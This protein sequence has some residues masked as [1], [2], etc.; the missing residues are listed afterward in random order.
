LSRDRGNCSDHCHHNLPAAAIVATV[1]EKA[2][3][4]TRWVGARW[5]SAMI[6]A[7]VGAGSASAALPP[8]TLRLE[9][10]KVT[11]S[12]ATLRRPEPPNLGEYVVDRAAL[13]RLGKALFWDEQLGSDG[14]A[15]ASCHYHAGADARSKNQLNPGFRSE[16]VP[17]GDTS[18]GNGPLAVPGA[19]AFGP[20]YQLTSAD[21]PFHR[22]SNPDD[23]TSAVLSDT[24]DIVSSQGV[25][26]AGSQGSGSPTTWAT[27]R[28]PV[29]SASAKRASGTSSRAT[30]PPPS[31]R[32]ST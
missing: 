25:F 3:I 11:N 23:R 29:C 15:C 7:V 9:A 26:A 19:P 8:P 2:M 4:G 17:G 16:A 27:R 5:L 18:F 31:T 14:M 21:F 32:S 1:K 20:N 28:L 24:N 13:L 10:L 6:V 12:L 22:L 30:P